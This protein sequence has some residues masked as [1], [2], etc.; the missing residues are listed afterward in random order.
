MERG[1]STAAGELLPDWAWGTCVAGEPWAKGKRCLC[2]RLCSSEH[3][4]TV[5]RGAWHCVALQASGK[6]HA[7]ATS[8]QAAPS[9]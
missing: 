1:G 6:W 8:G 9:C 4:I 3:M 7:A 2:M 5:S